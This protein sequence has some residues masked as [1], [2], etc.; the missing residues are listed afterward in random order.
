MDTFSGLKNRGPEVAHVIDSIRHHNKRGSMAKRT[1]KRGNKAVTH[2]IML[3][4]REDLQAITMECACGFRGENHPCAIGTLSQTI[5]TQA[6]RNDWLEHIVGE[7]AAALRR[8]TGMRGRPVKGFAVIFTP[9][10]S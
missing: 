6:L 4:A 1:K 2:R 5:A 3:D 9:M 10:G 8:V 7:Q